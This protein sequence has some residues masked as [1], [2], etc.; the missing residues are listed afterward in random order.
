MIAENGTVLCKKAFKFW[1]VGIFLIFTVI[2]N[3]LKVLPDLILYIICSILPKQVIF[4]K[5]I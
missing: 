4:I 5:T 1:C 2:E 3:I